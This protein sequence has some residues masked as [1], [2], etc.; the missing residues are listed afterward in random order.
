V[1]AAE[2]APALPVKDPPRGSE[3]RFAVLLVLE[4]GSYGI[5][6]RGPR[7]ADPI[8]CVPP[9]GCYV[10]HGPDHP[11][12]FLPG[13][14][15]MGFGN[16]MGK[17]AGACRHTLGC[18]FRDVELS[19]L[20][21]YLQPVDLHILK[22]DRRDPHLVRGDSDCTTRAGQLLCSKG[23]NAEDYVMWIVPE[24][25]ADAAGPHVLERALEEGLNLPRSAEL[26]PR[27]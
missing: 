5:R 12:A 21:G 2:P 23:V 20:P 4:P 16:T 26:S 24:S 6:R 17:R 8:L 19:S 11:A 3:T 18:V 22:H 10:S 15:A 1:P 14:K 9:N 27:R 25:L 7:T 13:R